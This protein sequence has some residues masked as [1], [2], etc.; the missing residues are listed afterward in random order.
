MTLKNHHFIFNYRNK[1]QM[2]RPLLDLNLETKIITY[3]LQYT[4]EVQWI[5]TKSFVSQ[6]KTRTFTAKIKCHTQCPMLLWILKNYERV[7]LFWLK[8][9]LI[10][11]SVM[12]CK[13]N[14]SQ[15]YWQYYNLTYTHVKLTLMYTVYNDIF[16]Y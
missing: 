7:R 8:K 2:L 13:S 16:L 9:E 12:K 1:N 10:L 4:K 3:Y 5:S 14:T 15:N 6:I 11:P